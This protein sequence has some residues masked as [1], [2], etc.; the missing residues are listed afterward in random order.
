MKKYILLLSVTFLILCMILLVDHYLGSIKSRRTKEYIK[1]QVTKQNTDNVSALESPKILVSKVPILM[2]HSISDLNPKSSLFVSPKSFEAQV[3]YLIKNNYNFIDFEDLARGYIP[4]NPIL[5]TFDDGYEDFYINAYPIL[6][7]N[8]LK[9]TVFII[10]GNIGKQGY[11]NVQEIKKMN[12]LISFQSHTVSHVDL[13]LL[14][15]T[16]LEQELKNSKETLEKSVDNKVIAISYPSGAYNPKVIQM[17]E[18]YYK[19]AVT[20]KPGTYII[21]NNKLTMPRIRV[22]RNEDIKSFADTIIRQ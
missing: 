13:R 19:Y 22:S 10:T 2:Y 11:L 16:Q 3:N 14:N 9:A 12:W 5:L 20:T 6:K 17:S 4:K 18:E 21:E 7:K 1:P 15:Y 8:N